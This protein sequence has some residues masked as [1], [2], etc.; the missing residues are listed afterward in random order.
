MLLSMFS[1]ICAQP[2]VVSSTTSSLP[3]SMLHCEAGTLAM[4]SISPFS[5]PITAVAMSMG[6]LTL[7]VSKAGAP[8]Q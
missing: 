7:S 1:V 4:T 5:S 8:S 3:S 2:V 6:G